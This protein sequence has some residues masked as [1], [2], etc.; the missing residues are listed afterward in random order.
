L[1]LIEML[2]DVKRK[3]P[4]GHFYYYTMTECSDLAFLII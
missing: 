2:L 1:F 4:I 3:S